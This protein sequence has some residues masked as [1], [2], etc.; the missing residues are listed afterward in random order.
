MER[1]YNFSA[2]PGALPEAVLAKAQKE[3]LNYDNTGMSVMEMSH[4]SKDY[5]AIIES[6]EQL[7]RELMQ[8]PDNYKVLF[9]QGGATSQF[10]MVPLNLMNRNNK[11]DYVDTGVWSTKAIKEAGRYGKVNVVASSADK[12]FSYI[13]KLDQSKFDLGADYFHITTNNTIYG[14]RFNELPNTG[15]VPLVGDMSSDILSKYYDVTNFGLIYAGAQKNMGPAGVCV[16][17]VKEELLGNAIDFTP[18]MMNYK[19]HAD[20]GSMFNTPPTYGIYLCKLVYEWLKEQGG[21]EAIAKVNIDKAN[22]LYEYLDNSELFSGTA[23]KEDRS[24]MNVPF[25]T[26]GHQLDDQFLKEAAAK[27][28]VNLKGHRT[29]GGM[30]A[31][32]YN[33]MPLLTVQKLVDFMKQFEQANK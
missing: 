13:P 1:V 15:K 19:N 6:A 10:A 2:G 31:S 4:R 17:I 8:V 27:G 22:A 32:I 12:T 28:F 23:A 14:T 29:T 33:A 16:V 24:I 5:M 21:V 9:L 3:L 18:A 7:L 20:N 11:A 25:I 30:R 26:K